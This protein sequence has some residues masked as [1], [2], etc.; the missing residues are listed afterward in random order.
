MKKN[1]TIVF[2]AIVILIVLCAFWS[3][4]SGGD[5]DSGSAG[6][7]GSAADLAKIGT[8]GYPLDGTYEL[9][10]DIT[11]PSNWMPIGSGNAPFTGTF[12]GGGYSI[13]IN[14][15]SSAGV[16][17][18]SA[19]VMVA[20]ASDWGFAGDII[21]RG[22]FAYTENATIKNLDITVNLSSSPFVI[23]STSQ[24]VQLFGTVAAAALNTAFTNINISGGGLDVEASSINGISV[25]GIVGMLLE[26]NSMT[27]CSMV[28]D[29]HAKSTASDSDIRA[30]G[31]AGELV[32]SSEGSLVVI[33]K[34]Y[35][36]GAV[37]AV[38]PVTGGQV[39]VGGIVGAIQETVEITD[40]Y[41]TGDVS[42]DAIYRV[43][44][45][46]I[47]GDSEFKDGAV[48]I[49]RC[50]ASGNIS[51]VD[52]TGGSGTAGGIAGTAHV[53]S[54]G[55]GSGSI[56]GCAA[57][58]V[59]V[60]HTNSGYY[61]RAGRIVGGDHSSDSTGFSLNKNI[62]N[63]DMLVNSSKI[64]NGST[65]NTNGEDKTSAQLEIQATY[66]ALGWDFNT[67]WKMQGGRPVL[68]W[69]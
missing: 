23:T 2:S 57:L 4:D 46:G 36:T 48:T 53:E 58:S 29:V 47:A 19:P 16:N 11:L 8:S 68:Q 56:T 40:C 33:R 69:Q 54:S 27:N 17:I 30:G 43:R 14:S 61:Y 20:L 25:G 13:I 9:T 28:G 39:H 24:Q 18:S 63:K 3:C 37:S 59:S 55:S 12:D 34:S 65:A 1:Y 60:S 64:L 50:Y 67:V 44:A 62:A 49:A 42:G 6:T 22:L 66:T 38:I 32:G 31:L 45:G 41:S 26:G 7:V 10:A 52:S 21:A 35:S 15:F 5:D 51:A